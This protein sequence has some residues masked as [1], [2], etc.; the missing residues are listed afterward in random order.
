M[1]SDEPEQIS[2][3]PLIQNVKRCPLSTLQTQK[4]R[5][6]QAL[7]PTSPVGAGGVPGAPQPPYLLSLL[8]FYRMNLRP[9]V[10]NPY[11]ASAK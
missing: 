10:F 4:G 5:K 11:D 2:P 7:L 8:T 6:A 3:T 1:G 9:A